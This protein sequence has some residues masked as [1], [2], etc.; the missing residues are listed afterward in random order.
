MSRHMAF[1]NRRFVADSIGTALFW[2]VVYAPIFFYTSK[3]LEAGLIG[4]ASA[5]VLEGLLGG[6]YG[7]FLDWFRRKLSC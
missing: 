2:T 4:L 6:P 5:A 3:S 1:L 7:K